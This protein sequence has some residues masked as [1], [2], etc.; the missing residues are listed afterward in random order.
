MSEAADINKQIRESLGL[1]AKQESQPTI[2]V[3][4]HTMCDFPYYSYST[5][6]AAVHLLRIDYDDGSY[7]VPD[8]TG[9]SG[10]N[11]SS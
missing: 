11:L 5:K 10:K 2:P 7:F 6:R 8:S 3:E 4:I 9:L 1:S